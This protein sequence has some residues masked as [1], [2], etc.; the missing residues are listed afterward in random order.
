M[1]KA[2]T[3]IEV[4]WR[5]IYGKHENYIDKVWNIENKEKHI[6]E[7]DQIN[8]EL[9][10][11]RL[12]QIASRGQEGNINVAHIDKCNVGIQEHLD[13]ASQIKDPGSPMQA[14]IRSYRRKR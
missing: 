3:E 13:M 11:G 7:R 6:W 2:T 5:I 4:Y 10:R 9:E 12:C 14:Q 8:Q 1:D